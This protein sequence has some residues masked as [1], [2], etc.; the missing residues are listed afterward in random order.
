MTALLVVAL[1]AVLTLA[2]VVG[3][4]L[5]DRYCL[6]LAERRA[7]EYLA[8]PFGR[9]PVVRIHGRW[10][11]TQ[12]VR[13]R[14]ASVHVT[15]GGL[16]I[17]EMTGAALDA[18]LRNVYL[19]LRDLV[20]RQVTELPC[21][22]LEGR[23][24]LPYGELARVANVPGLELRPSG[25]RVVAT[26]ALPVPGISQLARV[27]GRAVLTLGEGNTVWL[28]VRGVSVAGI[29][30]PSVV[31]HQLLPSLDVPIPLP[32]LPYGLRIEEV[33]PGEDGLIVLGSAAAVV[34]RRLTRPEPAPA[35]VRPRPSIRETRPGQ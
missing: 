34:F 31:L 8:V 28:R 22:H 27:S 21:E 29:S 25:D 12:A 7:R 23:L 5:L 13:G 17:G 16:R 24:V 10:F 2:V 19:S 14:Y 26:A 3:L 20:R 15:G 6:A 35:P 32:P 4:P 18:Q 30:L 9:P 33:R 1:L 11:L